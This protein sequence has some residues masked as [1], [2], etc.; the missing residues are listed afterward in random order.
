MVVRK[1]ADQQ[2]FFQEEELWSILAQ[3]ALAVQYLHQR[4]ILHRDIKVQNIF[5]MKSG[6]VSYYSPHILAQTRR[7]RHFEVAR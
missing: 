5:I 2:T 6:L 7:L 4:K 1:K 3:L